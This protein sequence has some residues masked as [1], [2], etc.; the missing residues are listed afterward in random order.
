MSK[1]SQKQ[2]SS[3]GTCSLQDLPKSPTNELSSPLRFLE[4][5]TLSPDETVEDK[6]SELHSAIIEEQVVSMCSPSDGVINVNSV[7]FPCNQPKVVRQE[8]VVE[9]TVEIHD[10]SSTD[11]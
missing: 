11:I 3:S 2:A 1:L 7:N 6:G 10:N 8:A 5:C 4:I 9:F